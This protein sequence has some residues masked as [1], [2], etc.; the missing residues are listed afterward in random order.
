MYFIKKGKYGT[1][2]IIAQ[3]W[4]NYVGRFYNVTVNTLITGNNLGYL[5]A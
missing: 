5:K 3:K 1:Q 2:E 4:L